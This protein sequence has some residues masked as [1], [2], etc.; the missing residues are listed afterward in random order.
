MNETP[1]EYQTIEVLTDQD[2]LR[3]NLNRPD[4]RNAFNPEMIGELARVAASL[5]PAIRAVVMSG[6]GSVF[7]AGGDVQWMRQSLQLSQHQNSEDALRLARMFVALDR[8]PAPLVG[9]IHGAALGGGVGLVA[10]CDYAIASQETQFGFTEARLGILPATIA[11][12][13]VRKIGPGHARSLFTTAERFSAQ[14]AYE[15]GLIHKIVDSPDQLAKAAEEVVSNIRQ[16][17]FNA[18]RIAKEIIQ[19]LTVPQNEDEIL[20]MVADLLAS[21][22]VSP[23][24]QEGLKAFLEKRSPNWA[25]KD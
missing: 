2:V 16:C 22:R 11:P 10:V 18:V 7:S 19:N 23:E 14:K 24:G 6:N 20:K 17:G 25:K 4:V 13:V 5:T 15:I 9:M 3:V 8:T 1:K 21:V 12:F